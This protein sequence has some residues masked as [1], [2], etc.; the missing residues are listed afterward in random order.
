[1][2]R[3]SGSDTATLIN[4]CITQGAIVP[5]E[6]TVL[7]LKKAM[8]KNGWAAKKYVID[9]FPR[10]KNNKD[11]W[12]A[13]M[14]DIVDVPFLLFLDADQT[15]MQER[16]LER[17]KES[18]RNDDNV[19]VLKKR[20]GTFVNETMPVV[21]MFGEDGKCRKVNANGTIEEI[22]AKVQETLKDVV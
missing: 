6:I 4:D 13:K 18:G 9:G 5:V 17:S 8:E 21:G 1:M 15:V 2:K 19:D 20:F 3:D 22:F 16:I 7:L 10:N 14:G 11:G 12:F